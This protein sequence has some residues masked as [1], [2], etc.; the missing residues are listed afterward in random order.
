MSVFA[1][2]KI[3]FQYETPCNTESL[4]GDSGSFFDVLKEGELWGVLLRTPP[5]SRN[6]ILKS[7]STEKHEFI[8]S[9]AIFIWSV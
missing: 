6:M 3:I 7:H 2:Y 5:L 4:K 9:K 8:G 1:V